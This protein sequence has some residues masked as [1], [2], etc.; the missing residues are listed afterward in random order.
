MSLP[1]GPEYRVPI[2]LELERRGGRAEPGDMYQK[3]RDHFPRE[4]F[5][6]DDLDEENRTGG[7]KYKKDIQGEAD[8][9]KEDGLIV[10]QL[11]GERTWRITQRGRQELRRLLIEKHGVATENVDD[12]ITGGRGLCHIDPSWQPSLTHR[13]LKRLGRR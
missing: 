3:I 1:K 13:V 11:K 12:F 10:R 4:F 9:M 2:L 6:N 7:A 5:T 8:R